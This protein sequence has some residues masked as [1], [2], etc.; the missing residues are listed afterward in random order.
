MDNSAEILKEVQALREDFSKYCLATENRLTKLETLVG[1][2][3]D[4]GQPGMLTG[5]RK[6][7]GDLKAWRW[8]IA[9]LCTGLSGAAM[10][11][12]WLLNFARK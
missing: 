10:F 4:N 9:G 7:I 6:D 5:F 11:A 8:K 12:G 2:L 3:F 1:P